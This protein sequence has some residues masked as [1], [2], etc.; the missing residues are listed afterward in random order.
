MKMTNTLLTLVSLCFSLAAFSLPDSD[1][2]GRQSG[3]QTDVF[4]TAVQLC[5]EQASLTE[6]EAGGPLLAQRCCKEC[7]KENACGNSCIAKSKQCDK[8]A[9]CGFLQ[10]YLSWR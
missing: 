5:F 8:G 10:H 9:G 7:K 1:A 2:I 6:H 4:V 3:S